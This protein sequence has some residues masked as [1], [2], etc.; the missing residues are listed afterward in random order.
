MRQVAEDLLEDSS[1]EAESIVF[2][3]VTLE[4]FNVHGSFL[5]FESSMEAVVLCFVW[6]LPILFIQELADLPTIRHGLRS[7]N[8]SLP[9]GLAKG[10]T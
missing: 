4:Q 1:S 3:S 6:I 5:D 2:L 10:N 7:L 9:V 8:L